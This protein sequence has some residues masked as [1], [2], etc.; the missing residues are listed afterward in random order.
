MVWRLAPSEL[1][2]VRVDNSK[3]LYKT[4]LRALQNKEYDRSLAY[5][6]EALQEDTVKSQALLGVASSYSLLGQFPKA[7][8]YFQQYRDQFGTTAAYLNDHG[9]S[10]M[11]RGNYLEAERQFLKASNRKPNSTT[12]KNNLIGVRKLQEAA[13]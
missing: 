8:Q 6:S 10:L 1:K 12:I 9:F 5:F 4:G 3:D 2:P 7:D 13:S 11:L